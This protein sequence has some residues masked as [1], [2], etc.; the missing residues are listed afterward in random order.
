MDQYTNTVYSGINNGFYL[1]TIDGCPLIWKS[2]IKLYY[3]IHKQCNKK[4]Q[5]Q[6]RSSYFEIIIF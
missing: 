3:R 6:A 1:L 5:F 2:G 4:N